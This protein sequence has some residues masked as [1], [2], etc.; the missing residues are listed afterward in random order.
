MSGGD[1][2]TDY[3]SYC[4]ARGLSGPLIT[5]RASQLRSAEQRMGVPLLKA[6]P[7]QITG[8]VNAGRA[9][10]LS[11]STL[12]VYVG[13]LSSF[14]GWA[15]I[16]GRARKSPLVGAA[17]PKRPRYLPRPI[18]DSD[19]GLAMTTAEPRVR[20]ILALAGMA[21]L[22]AIEIARLR[23]ED[24]VDHNDP[25]MLLIHG[26]GDKPRAV[27][28]SSTLLMELRAYGLP[29]RGPVIR[30]CD[31][32]PA[33]VSPSL[34]SSVANR[35]LHAMG[36]PDTLH[37]LRHRAGT[38][39]YRKTKDI[40]LVQDVLGH[41]SPRE[42]AIY[43]AWSKEDAPAAMEQLALITQVVL[44]LIVAPST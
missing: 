24:I 3:V 23:R 44:P 39:L 19:L 1:A 31:N 27:P 42:T 22:R 6:T 25:P 32:L 8:L 16:T 13:H 33:A 38:V 11:D 36:I 35:H 10:G 21:G 4:R 29:R 9:R 28:L 40:R 18:A 12:Y 20:V 26:K 43:S 37:S 7:E 34:V 30:R 2:I 15:M 5:R 14:Y 17:R 41:A